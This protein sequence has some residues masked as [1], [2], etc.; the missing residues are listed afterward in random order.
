MYVSV[1]LWQFKTA[2]FCG[3]GDLWS[4]FSLLLDLGHN[5]HQHPSV[6]LP[7]R[8]PSAPLPLTFG[9]PY[10]ICGH[11]LWTP[12]GHFLW[13]LFLDTFCGHFL[14]ILFCGYFFFVDTFVN[15]FCGFFWPSNPPLPSDLAPPPP[16]KNIYNIKWYLQSISV[17]FG[18]DATIQIG[19]QIHCLMY[20]E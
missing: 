6:P 20:A 12:F 1:C 18:I 8:S 10:A 5:Q 4:T 15:T 17:R 2:S 13:S 9:S 11:F 16:K 7:C 3:R 19:W 14:W